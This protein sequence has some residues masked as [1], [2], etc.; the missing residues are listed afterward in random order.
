MARKTSSEVRN[1]GKYRVKGAI[2]PW[3]LEKLSRRDE[4]GEEMPQQ[5]FILS[6][7]EWR[8]LCTKA[9][10]HVK[11]PAQRDALFWLLSQEDVPLPLEMF[12]PLP[13]DADLE[14]LCRPKRNPTWESDRFTAI[15]LWLTGKGLLEEVIDEGEDVIWAEAVEYASQTSDGEAGFGPVPRFG[16]CC[17]V[18][19]DTEIWGLDG[20]PVFMPERTIFEFDWTDG[21][22]G[23]GMSELLGVK[24]EP[25]TDRTAF[26]H[27][28]AHEIG[29]SSF[30][31]TI[32]D[33]NIIQNDDAI[34]GLGNRWISPSMDEAP[35]WWPVTNLKL[36]PSDIFSR[37]EIESIASG[38]A[39]LC[40]VPDGESE[41]ENC[42]GFFGV[43]CEEELKEREDEEYSEYEARRTGYV[44]RSLQLWLW[45]APGKSGAVKAK[46]E[47]ENDQ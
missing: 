30:I 25:F 33:G 18:V 34:R 1:Y 19:D 15:A 28:F 44:K 13:E 38:F 46:K 32:S 20:Y 37:E 45:G 27:Y 42:C 6:P 39:W 22:P 11:H 2:T 16:D 26:V 10:D 36:C 23:M 21:A 8:A 47:T 43:P 29:T 5:P 41:L 9:V 40:G 24:Y 4:E 3:R 7:V 14:K 31:R 35:E 17:D 12:D